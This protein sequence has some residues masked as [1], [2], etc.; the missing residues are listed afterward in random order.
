MEL[1]GQTYKVNNELRQQTQ[2][3]LSDDQDTELVGQIHHVN[4]NFGQHIQCKLPDNQDMELF[5]QTRYLHNEFEKKFIR[6]T[7]RWSGQ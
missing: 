6:T 2:D 5:G 4:N 3:K 1:L 7:V